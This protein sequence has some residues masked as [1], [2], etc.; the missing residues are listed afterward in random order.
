LRSYPPILELPVTA[1]EAYTKGE[2]LTV[3]SGAATISGVD[4]DGAKP[5][6]LCE[7]TK[8]A[9][10]SGNVKVHK[11]MPHICYEAVTSASIASNDIET[12]LTLDATATKV[13]ATTTKG[14][15]TIIKKLSN[16]LAV[17]QFRTL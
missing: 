6:Y 17:V 1:S 12:L 8:A 2:V 5:L 16:D 14:W 10:A 11:I 7:E 13:T 15:A 3:T 9:A 4:T